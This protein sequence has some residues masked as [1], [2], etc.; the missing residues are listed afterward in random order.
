M[1]IVKNHLAYQDNP[2]RVPFS[3]DALASGP[4]S[5]LS[6]S[7]EYQGCVKRQI[8]IL[9]SCLGGAHDNWRIFIETQ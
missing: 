9:K 7:H 2:V 3:V 1:H 5:S 4:I 6:V 8:N